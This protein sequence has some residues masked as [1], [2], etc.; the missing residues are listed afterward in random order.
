MERSEAYKILVV[1]FAMS[2][3][4][5]TR[6]AI[7]DAESLQKHGF[8]V[9]FASEKGVLEKELRRRRIPLHLLFF[10]DSGRYSRF[11]RYI[12][13]L[14]LST[15]LLL[16]YVLK[17]N[18]DFLYVQHRQSGLPSLIVSWLTG[19]K[20]VFIS[21]S[22]LGKY[23]RGRFMTPLGHNIIA[24]SN[25]VKQNIVNNFR[26]SPEYI[27]VISNATRTDVDKSDVGAMREFNDAWFIPHDASVVTCV[28][29]LVWVKAHNVLLS[30]WQRVLSQFPDAMLLLAGEGI[31]EKELKDYCE[32]LNISENVR[33][34][35]YVE[36]ISLVYSRAD[37]FV[38][39]SLSEGLP[40][41][42]LEAFSYGIPA[43][44]TNVSGTPEIVIHEETGILV[45]PDDS[46]QLAAGIERLLSDNDLRHRLGLSAR[47][48][49]LEK[50]SRTSRDTALADFF[51]NLCR[52]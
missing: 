23:N 42:I 2:P 7:D 15:I 19:A 34:M 18:Y 41:C 4:G 43:V 16:Y 10:V 28:A 50:Y 24:V 52:K 46:H 33:F 5:A 3:G 49:V 12:I 8:E 32:K 11:V 27:T 35:G 1:H 45:E 26:V 22:E 6:V 39:A 48:L 36:N 44:A 20:Y 14:P 29:S 9:E 30:A 31:L 25:H 37:F 17:N 21:H 40:L 13:G 47:E 51:N 38:L